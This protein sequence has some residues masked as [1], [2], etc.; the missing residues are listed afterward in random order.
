MRAV[1]WMLDAL[2]S[3]SLM[4]IGIRELSGQIPVFQMLFVR[5]F[6]GLLVIAIVLT[7]LKKWALVKTTQLKLH[8]LRNVFH[9]GG[10]YGWY[11]GIGLLPL[12]EVFALE[13]TVPFWTALIAALF[14][15]ERLTIH[16]LLAIACGFLGVMVIVQPGL[17]IVN[18]ASLIVLAA[19]IGYA[20]AH[21]STKALTKYDEPLVILFYMSAM[22]APVGLLLAISTWVEPNTQQWCWLLVIALTA[23]SAHFS[24]TKAMHYAEITTIVMIDFMRL[25][26]I[27]LVGVMLY[28]EPFEFTVILGG[29]LMLIGNLVNARSAIGRL[30]GNGK[31]LSNE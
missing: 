24:M 10:Q 7:I 16:K 12:A 28:Q 11:L 20:V 2:I 27:A 1:A 19:A 17:Q 25:P 30:K 14:L 9:F 18:S 5:S 13:F 4:A 3:F 23:L 29:T 31:L 8:S 22:Q 21:T 15:Q 6:V 26:V